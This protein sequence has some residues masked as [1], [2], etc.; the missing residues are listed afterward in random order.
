MKLKLE[1]QGLAQ[2]KKGMEG[3]M[4]EIQSVLGVAVG[5]GAQVIRDD[6]KSRIHSISGDLESGIISEVTWDKSKSKAFAGVGMDKG[7][8]DI[9]VYMSKV[10]ARYYI[11]SAVEYGHRAPGGAMSIEL[12]KKGKRKKSKKKIKAR[13]FMR[14]AYRSSTNRAQVVKIVEEYVAG[15]VNRGVVR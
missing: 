5:K 2:I 11:P 9:F 14:P 6:A 1:I 10:G 12:T 8:N 3:T 7:K 4:S 13:P 15:A